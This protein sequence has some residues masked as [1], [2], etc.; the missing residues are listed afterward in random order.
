MSSSTK[1]NYQPWWAAFQSALIVDDSR[2][3]R[4][5]IQQTIESFGLQTWL[6]VDGS[7]AF[8]QIES[9]LPSVVITDIE[10]PHCSGIGLL[11]RVRMSARPDIRDI[12]FIVVSSLDDAATAARVH[13]HHNAYLLSKPLSLRLLHLTL[14]LEATSLRVQMQ[15]RCWN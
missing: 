9:R 2:W 10:M 1:Q 13:R 11:D 15:N 3:S 8:K 5:M 14:Q 12:P 7:D 4:L 6:A